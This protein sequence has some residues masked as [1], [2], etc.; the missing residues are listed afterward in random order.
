MAIEPRTIG[1][2]A[3]PHPIGRVPRRR[4]NL[5][6]GLSH[7]ERVRIIQE[8]RRAEKLWEKS[9]RL[10]YC[11]G[12]EGP[13]GRAPD[14]IRHDYDEARKESERIRRSIPHWVAG[15]SYEQERRH[16]KAAAEFSKAAKKLERKDP[17]RAA[18]LHERAGNNELIGGDSGGAH[19]SFKKAIGLDPSA[20]NR[21]VASLAEWAGKPGRKHSDAGHALECAAELLMDARPGRAFALIVRAG[22]HYTHGRRNKEDCGQSA[23]NAFAKAAGMVEGENPARAS[24][25]REMAGD[26]YSTAICYDPCI[27]GFGT[28]HGIAAKQ[29]RRAAGLVRG[30]DPKRAAM[31]D[32][33][34]RE[35]ED[36][37]E[38]HFGN[39]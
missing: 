18:A 17:V 26:W 39:Y 33:K 2:R 27:N 28:M 32:G 10:F 8:L 21:I 35:E 31:L 3:H 9:A 22:E 34:A 1:A 6:D 24:E 38:R 36:A 16:S 37:E 20:R 29:Y 30:A 15:V 25:L 4:G 14:Y 5:V 11:I 12:P 23:A 13:A 7:E 19:G